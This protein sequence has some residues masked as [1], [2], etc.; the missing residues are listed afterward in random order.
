[1]PNDTELD[2]PASHAIADG[3]TEFAAKVLPSVGGTEHAQ[4]H[5]AFHFGALYVLQI[6]EEAVAHESAETAALALGM[7]TAELN[8]FV[9]AHAITTQ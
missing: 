8:E 4:A 3:G 6:L 1:M 9:R 5:I 2:L 7:L